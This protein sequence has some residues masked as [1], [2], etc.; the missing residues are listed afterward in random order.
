MQIT[1]SSTDTAKGP[2]DW[3]TGDVG[4]TGFV[5]QHFVYGQLEV[6][7][8]L[9]GLEHLGLERQLGCPDVLGLD[10]HDMSVPLES[11]GGCLEQLV[12]Q[13]VGDQGHV[14]ADPPSFS[15]GQCDR[16]LPGRV[17]DLVVPL[18]LQYGGQRPAEF[19]PAAADPAQPDPRGLKLVQLL[20]R[21]SN[22]EDEA[23]EESGARWDLKARRYAGF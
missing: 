10:D 19:A 22:G 5:L 11:L 3:F 17:T 2:T 12:I 1:R 16:N 20:V 23:T 21:R 13:L 9:P 6:A 18:G 8:H 4:F 14:P 7:R 15:L